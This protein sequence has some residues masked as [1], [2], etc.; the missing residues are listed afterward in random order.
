M[1]LF[2]EYLKELLQAKRM[3]I[4]ALSRLSGVERTAISK[5]LAGQRVLPYDALNALICHLRLTPGEEKRFRSYYDAQ[6]EK[7]GIRRSREVVG[8]LFSD[9]ARL[10]FSRPAFEETTLLL[11]LEQYA[12]ERSVFSGMTNVRP[13][14]RMA[15]SEEL[16]R[17]D[18]RIEMIIPPSD[19]LIH[20]ELLGR[21]L[22]GAIEAKVSQ[23]ITFDASGTEEEINLH[24][25]AA[26]CRILPVCLLSGRNYHPYYYYEND[27]SERYSDPFPYFLVTGNSVVC[28]SG[29]GEHAMLLRREDQIACYHR[30]FQMLLSRCYELI[31]Y[32]S[33]PLEILSAYQRCTELDGFYMAM[34]QPCFGRFYSDELIQYTSDPLEILSAYQRCTELDGFYMAM[35]QPCFGRFYSDELIRT[36]LRGELPFFEDILA[37]ACSRFAQLRQVKKFYTLFS[38]SGLKRFMEEG[39]LD[40]YPVSVVTPFQ[41]KDRIRLMKMLAEAVRSGDVTGRLLPQGIFPDYLSMC[42]SEHLGVGFFTTER[43]PLSEGV[44]SVQIQER[45]LC[46]AFHR[47]LVHLPESGRIMSAEETACV[48]EA[49]AAERS[50]SPE[51]TAKND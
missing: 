30:H 6:F 36:Y 24:N 44:C 19:T 33:D 9:L 7:E 17:P 45:G 51:K 10:D 47:W 22:N 46:R 15:I 41:K 21:Y 18:P 31:Q 26:F 16:A 40:D 12:G 28:L 14:L 2:S 20:D 4:S 49:L 48:L 43:F 27:V 37:A 38:E 39:T 42:T 50:F 5:A 23:I 34:D 11:S 3:T 8:K 32:T 1:L 13:L 29:D 35:D 25:L